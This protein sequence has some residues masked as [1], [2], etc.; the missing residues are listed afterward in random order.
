MS[1]WF[2]PF[3]METS[4]E[5]SRKPDQWICS[6]SAETDYKLIFIITSQKEI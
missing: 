5:G 3:A 1:K 6:E 4:T 2:F